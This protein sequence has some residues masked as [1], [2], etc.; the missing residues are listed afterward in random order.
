VRIGTGVK[1]SGSGASSRLFVRRKGARGGEPEEEEEVGVKRIS[2]PRSPIYT[3][4]VGVV[5]TAV[6]FHYR[7]HY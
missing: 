1:Q 6:V 4:G 3:R 5:G 2:Y 7:D